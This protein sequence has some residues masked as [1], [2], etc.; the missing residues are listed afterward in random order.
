MTVLTRQSGS[1]WKKKTI[2]C[3]CQ[4]PLPIKWI[5]NLRLSYRR[6]H[7]ECSS[8]IC[9]QNRHIGMTLKWEFLKTHI[10]GFC[11]YMN[12]LILKLLR[13]L[14]DTLK[15]DIYTVCQNKKS[16]NTLSKK[17]RWQ[18]RKRLWSHVGLLP[19]SVWYTYTISLNL[20]KKEFCVS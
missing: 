7:L 12:S 14:C 18:E 20:P 4:I 19:P 6:K 11:K 1:I 15:N 2:Q 17:F 8:R 5:M 9:Y 13:Q 10:K 16:E 3:R